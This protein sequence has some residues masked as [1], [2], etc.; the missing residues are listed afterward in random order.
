PAALTL[1]ISPANSLA[2]EEAYGVF[3]GAPAGFT[4]KFGRFL[5]AQGYLNEQHAHAWDFVDVP[6]VYQAFFGGQYKTD[7]AQVKWIAPIDHYVE[8]GGEIGAS[9]AFPGSAQ[10][11]N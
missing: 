8:V 9:D 1:S 10:N 2:V 6:L 7:G 5:S 11:R 3:T 4:P